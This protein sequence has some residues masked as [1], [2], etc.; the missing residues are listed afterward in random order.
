MG[1]KINHIIV[2]ENKEEY[3]DGVDTYVTKVIDNE[4]IAVLTRMFKAQVETT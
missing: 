2:L 1:L 3:I 4:L